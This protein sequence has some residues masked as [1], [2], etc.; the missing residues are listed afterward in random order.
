MNH[1]EE[2]KLSLVVMA[3]GLGSRFGGLKQLEPVGPSG[4]F[5]LEYSVYDAWKSGFSEL[6]IIIKEENRELFHEAI[7][8]KIMK[9]M[10]VRY[11]YQNTRDLPDEFKSS[12]KCKS[13][14]KPWGTGHAVLAAREA[15][16][17]PFMVINA[18]DFYGKETFS[19]MARILSGLTDGRGA[20]VS[21]PLERT[22]SRSGGV[23]RGLCNVD[24]L[25]FLTGV[26]EHTDIRYAGD[27][28]LS[29]GEKTVELMPD[30]QVSM[31]VWGFRPSML[32]LLS[33]EFSG[34][35]EH[36][37]DPEKEEFQLPSAVNTMIRKGR[38]SVVSGKSP[39]KWYGITYKEDKD[40]VKQGIKEQIILGRYK[41]RLWED[42]DGQ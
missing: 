21:F 7:G 17:H 22:M 36:I 2:A 24:E 13:R 23:S 4:E 11:V 32:P 31:N 15:I 34:F 20:F 10:D 37:G 18:D 39:E 35:L 29:Y 33:E 6:I 28:I 8:S 26:I 40:T 14:E 5:I 25:G 19:E 1:G 38:I 9:F 16:K 41:E 12:E 3:A 30:T 27:R 42:R